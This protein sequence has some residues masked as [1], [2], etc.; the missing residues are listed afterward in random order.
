MEVD[1]EK[2][3][4][5]ELIDEVNHACRKGAYQNCLSLRSL[6]CCFLPTDDPPLLREIGVRERLLALIKKHAPQQTPANPTTP[7]EAVDPSAIPSE[8][9]ISDESPPA[10]KINDLKEALA[11]L[12]EFEPVL[13][14]AVTGF[15]RQKHETSELVCLELLVLLK[16]TLLLPENADV[17]QFQPKFQAILDVTDNGNRYLDLVHLEALAR[18]EETLDAL[19]IAPLQWVCLNDKTNRS[20]VIQ[21]TQIRATVSSISCS[22]VAVI[23]WPTQNNGICQYSIQL[24]EPTT[25]AHAPFRVG[26][27]TMHRQHPTVL[28]G[29]DCTSIGFDGVSVY[30]NYQCIG[31]LSS[32]LASWTRVECLV[33]FDLGQMMFV[34]DDSTIL[35]VPLPI[36]SIIPAIGFGARSFRSMLDT[37]HSSM[38]PSVHSTLGYLTPLHVTEVPPDSQSPIEL[39]GDCLEFTSEKGAIC[40]LHPSVVPAP[41]AWTLS[42]FV[43][44]LAIQDNSEPRPWRTICLKGQDQTMERTASVFLS[45]DRLLLAVCVSTQSDWNS[46]LVS[47]A[48][49]PAD[50]WTHVAIVCDNLTLRLFIQGKEERNLTLNDAVVHNRHP[51]Y[52]GKSPPGVKKPT[53]DYKGFRGYL[54]CATFY[55]TRACSGKEILKQM[56]EKKATVEATVLSTARN[57]M[58]KEPVVQLQSSW[59]CQDNS[60]S[61][62]TP[63]NGCPLH[64]QEFFQAMPNWSDEC[65]IV[66]TVRMHHSS[67]PLQVLAACA[68]TAGFVF[69]WGVTSD[70]RLSVRTKDRKFTTTGQYIGIASSW[71]TVGWSYTLKQVVFYVNGHAVESMP[72]SGIHLDAAGSGITD[73][74][75][76]ALPFESSFAAQW[77]GDI[78]DVKILRGDPLKPATVIS[79]YAFLEGEGF[80]AHD[81]S[82][83]LPRLHGNLHRD[84]GWR[85][86][87]SPH[88]V[89]APTKNDFILCPEEPMSQQI[90]SFLDI[91]AS[92]YVASACIQV[93]SKVSVSLTSGAVWPHVLTFLLLHSLLKK[94]IEKERHANQGNY[95]V[96]LLRI[97]R[98][99]F[100]PLASV[101]SK[102]LQ[103]P[104][105]LPPAT[106]G[107]GLSESTSFAQR[108]CTMLIELATTDL[109]FVEED[110]MKSIQQ[111]A[112]ETHVAGL[113]IFYPTTQKRA[114]FLVNSLHSPRM[115]EEICRVLSTRRHLAMQFLPFSENNKHLELFPWSVD[116][117]KKSLLESKS[118]TP[119]QV[120]K[121]LAPFQFG[122]DLEAMSPEQLVVLYE[123][124]HV[125]YSDHHG[126][127]SV[128]NFK[129]VWK[130]LMQQIPQVSHD[131]SVYQF[132]WL[133]QN[134]LITHLQSQDKWDLS[135]TTRL[136][137]WHTPMRYFKVI[138]CPIGVRAAPSVRAQKIGRTLSI[139]Q[140][141][142]S[143]HV[144]QKA[145]E[146][147]LYV[148]HGDGWVFDVDPNDGMLLLEEQVLDSIIQRTAE[149]YSIST[150]LREMI[151]A[152]EMTSK[153]GWLQYDQIDDG[154]SMSD[155]AT[156]LTYTSDETSKWKTALANKSIK[157][158]SGVYTWRIRVN[159]CTSIGQILVGLST[160]SSHLNYW[161]GS[162]AFSFGW[163]LTGDFYYNGQRAKTPALPLF[164]SK[165]IPVLDLIV[166]TNIGSL[167]VCNADSGVQYGSSHTLELVAGEEYFPAVSL[168]NRQ[169]SVSW[170]SPILFPSDYAQYHEIPTVEPTALA[171]F[172]VK[173]LL[174]SYRNALNH[175]NAAT[176]E[177]LVTKFASN[178]CLWS[179]MLDDQDYLLDM[180]DDILLHRP[181][182]SDDA[183][184]LGCLLGQLYGKMIYGS[185]STATDDGPEHVWTQLKLF[186]GGLSKRTENVFLKQ[187]MDGNCSALDKAMLRF[188]GGSLLV[189][190][191]GGPALDRAIRG[192][193]AC[194]LFHCGMSVSAECL[195]VDSLKIP[196]KSLRLVWQ[197]ALELK[198]W[199]LRYKTSANTTYDA[200]AAMLTTKVELL[201][202][203]NPCKTEEYF[204]PGE[205]PSLTRRI[206]F[207]TK[208]SNSF[209]SISD[210]SAFPEWE[211]EL[212]QSIFSFF[213]DTECNVK[214]VHDLLVAAQH[215]AISR[216]AGLR[217][218]TVIL[219]SP[220]V[221]IP[222]K[223]GIL[224]HIMC[225][226]RQ[227]ESNLWHYQLGI[228]GCPATTKR[229]VHTAFEGY[230]YCI[231]Q[232]LS[233]GFDDLSWQL[234]LLDASA[235][236]VLPE[237]HIMLA[238]CRI[239]QILQEILDRTGDS[240]SLLGLR[241]ATMKVVY[242]LAVQVASEG[243]QDDHL[244]SLSPPQFKR[245]LSG[246][247]TL[248]GNVFDMLFSEIYVA[249]SGMMEVDQ[250]RYRLDTIGGDPSVLGILSL[251]QFVSTSS[252]CQAFLCTP[253]WLTL[254]LTVVCFGQVEAQAR[255]MQ[256]LHT[257]LPL[258][259]PTFLGV[260]LTFDLVSYEPVSNVCR[261]LPLLGFFLDGIGQ[262]MTP[263][264]KDLQLLPRSVD[265]CLS[266]GSESVSILRALLQNDSWRDLV[267]QCLVNG[268]NSSDMTKQLGVLGVMGSF[269]EPIRFGAHIVLNDGSK[270]TII[271]LNN[272]TKLMEVQKLDDQTVCT[273]DLDSVQIV[274]LTSEM[275]SCFPETLLE[276][277]LAQ[278]S[279]LVDSVLFLHH[280]QVARLIFNQEPARLVSFVTQNIEIA[281]NVFE[282][283]ATLTNSNGL[284]S[285]GLLEDKFE[286]IRRAQYSNTYGAVRDKLHPGSHAE[287][288]SSPHATINTIYNGS[289][290]LAFRD[291]LLCTLK[292]VS[293]FDVPV[294]IVD[295]AVQWLEVLLNHILLKSVRE[296][297]LKWASTTD[298]AQ[299]DLRDIK[300]SIEKIY[301]QI[302]LPEMLQAACAEANEWLTNRDHW[303]KEWTV[304]ETS[305]VRFVLEQLSR[306]K[307][308]YSIEQWSEKCSSLKVGSYLCATS[309]CLVADVLS[310]SIEILRNEDATSPVITLRSIHEAMRGDEELGR[311]LRYHETYLAHEIVAQP[312]PTNKTSD[313][314]V[315]DVRIQSMITMGFP[316]SWCR[317]ALDESGQDV[318]AALNWILTNG[319]ILNEEATESTGPNTETL[320]HQMETKETPQ[321]EPAP[322]W[323]LATEINVEGPCPMY[324]RLPSVTSL[325]QFSIKCRTGTTLGLYKTPSSMVCEIQITEKSIELYN[326][327]SCVAAESGAF[328]DELS[329]IPYWVV[330]TPNEVLLGQGKDVNEKRCIIRWKRTDLTTV[331]CFSFSSPSYPL[332]ITN[333]S[334]DK[335]PPEIQSPALGPPRDCMT[336]SAHATSDLTFC[337]FDNPS[338]NASNEPFN[339]WCPYTSRM[340]FHEAL[341]RF[342]SLELLQQVD[343]M[344]K[345][346]RILYARRFGLSV[347]SSCKTQL[348]DI[349]KN[350]EK[351]FVEF[352]SL[353]SNRQWVSDLQQSHP[354]QWYLPHKK[355][356]IDLLRPTV[357]FICETQNPLSDALGQYLHTEMASFLQN[358]SA[359][360][361][362]EQSEDKTDFAVREGADLRFL[363]LVTQWLL[364]SSTVVERTLFK[365]WCTSLKCSNP[366]VKQTALQVLSLIMHRALYEHVTHDLEAYAQALSFSYVKDLT[367]RILQVEEENYPMYSRYFQAHVEFLAVF[368]RV[369]KYLRIPEIPIQYALQFKGNSSHADVNSDDVLP[370]WTAQYTVYPLQGGSV[371]VL[372]NSKFSS[373]QLKCG[374]LFDGQPSFAVKVKSNSQLYPFLCPIPDEMWSVVTLTASDSCVTLY[375]NGTF[376]SSVE[377]KE[378]KLPMTHIGD[379]NQGFR[380]WLSNVRY[381]DSILSMEN[382]SKLAQAD[383]N[384][385]KSTHDTIDI[386]CHCPALTAIAH[387]PMD[388]GAG[389]VIRDKL[390][391]FCDIPTQGVKWMA[392]GLKVSDVSEI[393]N[394]LNSEFLEKRLL[395]AG[396]GTFVQLACPPL[397]GSWN[398]TITKA[399]SLSLFLV[400]SRT[401][402]GKLELNANKICLVQGSAN[403]DGFIQFSITGIRDNQHDATTS[404][405]E[406]MKDLKF[407][408]WHRQGILKGTWSTSLTRSIP[409][410]YESEMYFLPSTSDSVVLSDGGRI[411]MSVLRKNKKKANIVCL[412]FGNDGVRSNWSSNGVPRSDLALST[413]FDIFNH[414]DA[415]TTVRCDALVCRGKVY[416]EF[417]L[418]TN[419]LMQLGYACASFK[420][421]F[422]SHGVGDHFGSFGVDGKRHKKW[423]HTGLSYGGDWSWNAGDI[424]GVL[425]DIDQGIMRFTHQGVDLGVAFTQVDYP[426]VKWT[427]GLYPA[428]SFSSGQGA[429]FNIGHSPFHHQPPGY[430]SVLEAATT[431]SRVEMYS[432][433]TKR[434]IPINSCHRITAE[435]SCPFPCQ[436]ISY[437]VY[438]WEVQIASLTASDGV[439][440]GVC[441]EGVN[442]NLLLGEDKFGW[443]LC[444]SGKTYHNNHAQ[445]FASIGFAQ[446][447]R[448]GIEVNMYQ[449]TL[450][451]YC[452]RK[453]LGIAFNQ[454][455]M[456]LPMQAFV[457]VNQQ[458]GFVPAVSL[459]RPQSMVVSL[460]LKEGFDSIQ[461][462]FSS[463]NQ[464]FSGVWK[465]GQRDGQGK[466]TLKDKEGY[467]IGNWAENQLQG[468][469]L[470]CEPFPSCVS[471]LYPSVW[472]KLR[473]QRSSDHP[474]RA[475]RP[476]RFDKGE[477]VETFA[478][479]SQEEIP[480]ALGDSPPA[481]VQNSAWYSDV[482][483]VLRFAFESQPSSPETASTSM[484]QIEGSWQADKNQRFVL[485]PPLVVSD[486]VSLASDLTSANLESH[487]SAGNHVLFRG[488]IEISSGV[489]YWEV[490]VQACTHG[491][492]FIGIASS[493]ITASEG[494]GDFGFVSYRVRWSQA[495]GEQ[496]YGRYFS[497]GDTI[498]VRFDME[499]GTLSFVK[500]GDDFTRGRPAVINM[501]VAFRHLRSQNACHHLTFVPVVGCS[502]P[503]DSFTVRGY[504]WHSFLRP[505]WPALKLDQALEAASAVQDSFLS[506]NL[507]SKAKALYFSFKTTGEFQ[508]KRY[509]S[510]GGILVEISRRMAEQA[511][512]RLQGK[513]RFVLRYGD[514]IVLGERDGVIWYVIEGDEAAGI[515]YWTQSEVAHLLTLNPAEEVPEPWNCMA[516]TMLNEP[517]LSKCQ[518]CDTPREV[519]VKTQDEAN[520]MG[521]FEP[522]AITPEAVG[523]NVSEVTASFENLLKNWTHPQDHVLVE[524]M[525][526]LCD[527][528]GQDPEN[529]EWS[530]YWNRVQSLLDFNED[531]VAARLCL[532]LAWNNEVQLL[533][534]FLDF[535][536]QDILEPP[537]SRT[538]NTLTLN[539]QLM[540][541]RTKVKFWKDVLEITT[542]H[543]TP[544]SDEYERPESLREV[545][546]NRILALDEQATVKK[547]VFGQL[548]MALQSWDNHTL[549]RAYADE[550][551]DAGQRRA[552]YVKFLGEG[553][554]DH[555][556]PYR[557]V[558]QTAAWDEPSGC[559]KLFVPCPNANTSSEANQDKFVVNPSTPPSNL[560]FLGK[561]IGMAA[562]HR[563]MVPLNCSDLFWKPLVG[564]TND[565]KDLSAV[566]TQL[567]RAMHDMECLGEAEVRAM[568][569]DE[570]IEYLLQVTSAPRNPLMKKMPQL[571]CDSLARIIEEG[572]AYKLETIRLQLRSFMEGLAG[573]LPFSLLNLFTPSQ[574]DELICGSP[575]IDLDMLQR[576]TVYEGVDPLAPHIQYFWQC[577]QDMTH[578]Q[579]SAFVNFVLARSRLPRSIEEFTLHFKIQPAVIT[580]DNSNPDQYLPHS[581]TC[582]FSLSLPRY[583]SK[584]ICMEKLLYAITNSPTMDADFVERGSAGWEH[585]T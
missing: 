268:Y 73:L 293:T 139:G 463:T 214:R 20:V 36:Q 193:I 522:L 29:D 494:W 548:Q 502:H 404:V 256:L 242:L 384:Q 158:G 56:K 437:G 544:P 45:C 326:E 517:N 475:T 54:R 171:L 338:E 372:A 151:H 371:A 41:K 135:T 366:H 147:V 66:A 175:G 523:P 57:S 84:D 465:Q 255:A 250:M 582:F 405:N 320:V 299:C 401:I 79:H 59:Q 576:I 557:A 285:L 247:Q 204:V 343:E 126:Q 382:I 58:R 545:S 415:F 402:Q 249:V 381:F 377:I 424:I 37:S 40:R 561:L 177:P 439:R 554:D 449:G 553:V 438:V 19:P 413:Q 569:P 241:Q 376:C 354:F 462:P 433:R 527:D 118:L 481:Q 195:D 319:D 322:E 317:R 357:Q 43:Y 298:I 76:G 283:G 192:V 313:E 388:E 448:I 430:L 230:Y 188:V 282:I 61:Y 100:K 55:P 492:L 140:V 16:A 344:A 513:D 407:E 281:R 585:L 273:M 119:S 206:S 418:K 266:L 200:I 446:G 389:T 412:G 306:S 323:S 286:L 329:W 260:D 425:L 125:Y 129:H 117:V 453:H 17:A 509:W 65:T 88:N 194:M 505:Q 225:A 252:V 385:W 78:G 578:V 44:P 519:E 350:H 391:H 145:D 507:V 121:I 497:A 300:H 49:L 560:K 478:A 423:C 541:K 534:P 584:E 63:S 528:I 311:L 479:P 149:P 440:V 419:G 467:Y 483:I 136:K 564:L 277:V 104:L 109:E 469:P 581:Q 432:H 336:A 482:P 429:A 248:S 347:L 337:F 116:E 275:I 397:G 435:I 259:D 378:L 445:R 476:H 464:E 42:F 441:I 190:R 203:L 47:N 577:L 50:T 294:D 263:L 327:N 484:I 493:L 221:T 196:P 296:L 457:K 403:D 512:E 128:D 210:E 458:G 46:T 375:V 443:A 409:P 107:L 133:L 157:Q 267:V 23:G 451:F 359:I 181:S 360:H 274:P 64:V 501:G 442:R 305:I 156:T 24:E 390:R 39:I 422:S 97:L 332:A 559:L 166:N 496:L 94:L 170:M 271:D 15:L 358:S 278:T 235:L 33:D 27:A 32:P 450:G 217:R 361:W 90:L 525:D 13:Y 431:F 219:N 549:R 471:T 538:A 328:C 394:Q 568:D 524:Q 112:I 137:Q 227:N 153:K 508:P 400:D 159:N 520:E 168:F 341:S 503:G 364:P 258:C 417:I 331:T 154:C 539:R 428:G 460:G 555:G 551:Q 199:A 106:V 52:F 164:G 386:S 207:G 179:S 355:T 96:S 292:Q 572:I 514:A 374:K 95:I 93:E 303:G 421:A 231:T 120:T 216:A 102:H 185:A 31:A 318:N 189:L 246:P 238:S 289:P 211:T 160:K 253:N 197:K 567:M 276:A 71:V 369:L 60:V 580:G 547:T 69:V 146:A 12:K 362:T 335:S 172:C 85:K 262:A 205:P 297:V 304:H 182:T 26:W 552:F 261:A 2:L 352:I 312:P 67:A 511:K 218:A 251:L 113:E 307:T 288:S 454:L 239:F 123:E 489:H 579:R 367:M 533:C 86:E 9:S 363:L 543:T 115:S 392:L 105:G 130:T 411:A 14:H 495:E 68:T 477:V 531:E 70:G 6:A 224:F 414:T 334:W 18:H 383:L 28:L 295:E 148:A 213:K 143:N 132:I 488:N 530:Q 342:S 34:V 542:T 30:H 161:I 3:K 532:L 201:L 558:F 345:I 82:F 571:T 174:S 490:G 314:K 167:V 269:P 487:A 138:N 229:D 427:D 8:P 550:L 202:G 83:T 348:G 220:S 393:E 240:P 406:W 455:S 500:D 410:R 486:T 222:V 21:D 333:I 536:G 399:L 134:E 114:D 408:G 184:V 89:L 186:Q 466:L 152:K 480:L 279:L 346:L 38:Y 470:W 290:N 546:L 521:D 570:F 144:V 365:I 141:I 98:A 339:V 215:K 127:L 169:D 420:P 574:F 223:A 237:D 566:D 456:H 356:T 310:L 80:V 110:T 325:V 468:E 474:M 178:M 434:Y 254:F 155:A 142:E 5:Q 472:K 228:A 280:V 87:S 563:I 461:Y 233:N 395:F 4:L 349:F 396:T 416:F 537:T 368:Q 287:L 272:E 573:V 504:K 187:F 444:S 264:T 48:P 35:N 245:Q 11:V 165:N 473:F 510:R 518:I 74:Y 565:R 208:R 81:V 529:V 257:L 163:M 22:T 387:W 398:Q 226:I 516:C 340:S 302:Q 575:E 209:D 232:L 515:W 330:C 447:N 191:V 111:E 108:L 62:F 10:T 265:S 51:F 270:G 7:V 150:V 485:I 162:N 243:E 198:A 236:R 351:L 526:S 77:E 452:N 379:P 124:W 535:H 491:S 309:E 212:L 380:G 53:T 353:V 562:R 25:G 91:M 75:V 556:G 1:R 180:V 72:S 315:L 308:T 499:E 583:S 183:L 122:F 301:N 373:I 506:A 324:W 291:G 234:V 284:L 436:S 101:F 459:F 321:P 540:F 176:M 316:E 99:N 498:G 92:K 103:V 426:Q 131:S 370:P 173:Q 244:C